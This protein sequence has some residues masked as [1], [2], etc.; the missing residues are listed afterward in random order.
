MSLL[1]ADSLSTGVLLL[2]GFEACPHWILQQ[3][4]GSFRRYTILAY[5]STESSARARALRSQL[6]VIHT[7]LP[8]KDYI[9]SMTTEPSHSHPLRPRSL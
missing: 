4:D 9:L 5:S 8:R 3:I 6:L 7:H 2:I 1:I